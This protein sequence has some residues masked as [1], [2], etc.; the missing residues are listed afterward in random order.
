MPTFT[1]YHGTTTV[2]DRFSKDVDPLH[3]TPQELLGFFFTDSP[4]IAKRFS[5]GRR[6][7]VI[8]ARITLDNPRIEPEVRPYCSKIVDIE[9][10]WNFD[11]TERY[12]RELEAEGVDGIIFESS[13]GFHEIAVFSADSIE[14]VKVWKPGD[15]DDTFSPIHGSPGV[16]PA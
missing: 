1:L 6:G 10:D 8:E 2:F 5:R 16:E 9:T 12:R 15:L 4:A 3:E 7:R 11:E 13:D 14:I